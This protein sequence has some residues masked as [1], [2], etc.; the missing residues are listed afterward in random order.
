MEQKNYG[1][2]FSIAS[3]VLGILSIVPILPVGGIVAAIVGLILGING[4]KK[5][6][7]QG[8]PYGMAT[9]GIVLS[10]I[11]LAGCVLVMVLCGGIVAATGVAASR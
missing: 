2:G 9:A 8:E 7:E 5:L 6:Q 11:G 1:K 4:K 3:L 10:I